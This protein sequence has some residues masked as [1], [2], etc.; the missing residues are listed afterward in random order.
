MNADEVMREYAGAWARGEPETAFGFLA[1]DV[2]MHLPG[3]GPLA[4]S[5]EGKA[6]VVAAVRA[7]LARTDGAA[8]TV[9]V[10]DRLVSESA[11]ALLLREVVTRGDEEL[12][13]RRVNVYR[14]RQG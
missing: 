9:E 8:V 10:R 11:V 2:V 13:L 12:D 1:E 5:H 6:A 7:L 3:R 14:V 4:G